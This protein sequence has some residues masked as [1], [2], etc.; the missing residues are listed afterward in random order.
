MARVALM[1]PFA[2][3]AFV[4]MQ[5]NEVRAVMNSVFPSGPPKH[6]FAGVSGT[7]ILPSSFP[8]DENTCTPSPALDQRFPSTSHRIPSG[9]PLSILQNTR[10]LLSPL[11]APTSYTHTSRGLPLSATYNRFSSG[12]K[13]RPLGIS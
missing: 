3:V 5:Y 4:L 11:S 8:S 10:P 6:R 13:H 2:P 9:P 7:R 12:E 1:M